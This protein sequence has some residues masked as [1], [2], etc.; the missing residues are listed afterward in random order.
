[1]N[2]SIRNNI[3]VYIGQKPIGLPQNLIF[4]FPNE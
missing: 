3:I 4:M 2:A 1:M